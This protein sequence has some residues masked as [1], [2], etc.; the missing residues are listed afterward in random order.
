[1][2]FKDLSG[3]NG[4]RKTVHA[5]SSSRRIGSLSGNWAPLYVCLR[6]VACLCYHHDTRSRIAG[7]MATSEDCRLQHQ[8]KI[9]RAADGVRIAEEVSR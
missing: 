1:M 3:R 6:S 4:T 7:R 2:L 9:P 8:Q 5:K